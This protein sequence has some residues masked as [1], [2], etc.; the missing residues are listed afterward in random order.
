MHPLLSTAASPISLPYFAGL[1]MQGALFIIAV[2]H[3]ENILGDHKARCYNPSRSFYHACVATCANALL[4]LVRS[5]LDHLR[6]ESEGRILRSQLPKCKSRNRFG[7]A[8]QLAYQTVL[9]IMPGL[10]ATDKLSDE[11]LREGLAK[12]VDRVLRYAVLYLWGASCGFTLVHMLAVYALATGMRSVYNH[13]ITNLHQLLTSVVPKSGSE[14]LDTSPW[15]NFPASART[16]RQEPTTA[17]GNADKKP[18]P[19]TLSLHF[20][21]ALV[22]LIDFD[23]VITSPVSPKAIT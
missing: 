13:M 15:N 22:K 11:Q 18:L 17:S 12:T 1:I 3:I 4:K 23:H 5:T 19:T 6:A 2:K 8:F 16:L 9:L 10:S 20:A 7:D 21:I 14:K